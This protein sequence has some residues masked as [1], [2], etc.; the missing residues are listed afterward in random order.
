MLL[1]EFGQL[2]DLFCDPCRTDVNREKILMVSFDF[3]I[4]LGV[5]M[6]LS[7]GTAKNDLV[8]GIDTRVAVKSLRYE[9]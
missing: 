9:V 7:P 1:E 6:H 2:L 4:Y 8:D 3:R 5:I